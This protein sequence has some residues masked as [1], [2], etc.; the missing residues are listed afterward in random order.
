MCG[1]CFFVMCVGLAMSVLSAASRLLYAAIAQ[2]RA[3]SDREEKEN[4]GV[5]NT[6]R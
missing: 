4:G 2:L 6:R 3:N 5:L 1:V